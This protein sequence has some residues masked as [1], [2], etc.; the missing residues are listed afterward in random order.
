MQPADIL[1]IAKLRRDAETLQIE[2]DA[3]DTETGTVIED[4]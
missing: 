2:V 1:L 4:A 3:S